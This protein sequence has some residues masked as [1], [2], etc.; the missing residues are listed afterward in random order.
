M[1]EITNSTLDTARAAAGVTGASIAVWDG[2]ALTTAVAGVRNSVT[3][4][5]I[6]EDTVM[7]IGSISKVFKA[8]LVLHL[9]DDG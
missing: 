5:P 8:V 4:D 3:G 7:L 1:M 2:S 6:T 9:V